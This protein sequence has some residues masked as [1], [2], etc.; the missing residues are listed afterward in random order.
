MRD[1]STLLG[2]RSYSGRARAAITAGYF[3]SF[4]SIGTCLAALGPCLRQLSATLDVSI[5][6]L[7]FLFT[8]RATGYLVGSVAGGWACDRFAWTHAPLLLSNGL[9]A[10]G[11][12]LVPMLRSAPL[13]ALAIST[14]GVC[15]GV[16]DTGGNVLLLWLWGDRV[17]PFMQAMHFFFG[18]GAFVSPLLVE[19]AIE[20][21]GGIAPAWSLLAA[22]L[23]LAGAPLLP[24]GGPSKPAPKASS[25]VEMAT[26][27]AADS[28]AGAPAEA[29]A[30]GA[31][32]S[33]RRSFIA[34]VGLVLALYVGAEVGFGGF[35]FLYAVD[36]FAWTPLQA[37]LLNSGFWG[38]L[39]AGR[40]LA[41]PL[42]TRFSPR[43]LLVADF[44][45]S[46][47]AA[48]CFLA[49]PAGSETEPATP[50]LPWATTLFFG[51][52]M[53]SVF[54]SALT[55]AERV[56]PVT[57]R[58]ASMFVVSAAF[59]E[60]LLPLCIAALYPHAHA[61]FPTLILLACCAEA[62]AF[63]GTACASARLR[64]ATS[65]SESTTSSTGH[66]A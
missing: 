52:S 49:L 65:E 19:A 51:L 27:A 61:A 56:T 44:V 63:S 15:M 24:F 1:S 34:L 36:A 29:P 64:G 7:G 2:P 14:Q 41:I 30:A 26:A 10:L 23:V 66:G 6:S 55:Y 12:A 53:A 46:I 47:G 5:D 40:L 54:P 62:T 17:E 31:A 57:G 28:E 48:L 33:R 38:A 18:L 8:A 32:E 13:V 42:S 25:E 22:G 20:R 60:M 16:L 50:A 35:C 4:F 11:S 43:Q 39:A 37:R 58:V 59:G 3:L 9:C 45:G 21:T